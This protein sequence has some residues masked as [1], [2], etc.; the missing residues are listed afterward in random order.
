MNVDYEIYA[1]S[2]AL[3]GWLNATVQLSGSLPFQANT[4]LESIAADVQSR[5]S[6]S[7]IAHFKMTLSPDSG[8]GYI[9]VI[10]VVRNDIIPELSLSLEA[11]VTNAQLIINLRAEAAPEVLRDAV[12]DAIASANSDA[13]AA[14]LEHLEFFRPGKPVPTHRITDLTTYG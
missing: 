5:L 8:L 6:G 12:R 1:E 9:A 4:V 2:E 7:E 10:N 3:L 14:Q 11:P 13:L